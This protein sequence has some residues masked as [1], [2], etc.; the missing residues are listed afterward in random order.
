M[1]CQ[2]DELNESALIHF[3]TLHVFRA[4]FDAGTVQQFQS[5]D[6][7]DRWEYEQAIAQAEKLL[8]R[9]ESNALANC[10]MGYV[11]LEINLDHQAA[12]RRGLRAQTCWRTVV[13]S[14]QRTAWRD[15]G[16]GI[17]EI[18]QLIEEA[19]LAW[20]EAVLQTPS[21][22][23]DLSF[24]ENSDGVPEEVRSEVLQNLQRIE[25]EKAK[26]AGTRDAFRAYMES[27]PMSNWNQEA[28]RAIQTLDFEQ[29]QNENS[30]E[31]WREFVRRHPLSS[32]VVLARQEMDRLA[33]TQ[34]S[35]SSDANELEGYINEFPLGAFVKDATR[36]RDSLEWASA[37]RDSV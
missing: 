23:D 10:V 24:L 5:L 11:D 31:K 2:I 29:A 1:L 25:F 20:A 8:D 3:H 32:L 30:L 34:A 36:Q 7:L 22:Q 19:S 17:E 21:I 37:L 15:S 9:E 28:L 16:F 33:Y 35:T 12:L 26:E 6:R 27:F 14:E 13:T 4:S 18:Q